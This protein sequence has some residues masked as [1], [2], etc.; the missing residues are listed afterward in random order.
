MQLH[1]G[2][3]A[4]RKLCHLKAAEWTEACKAKGVGLPEAL[5]DVGHGVKGDYSS[6]L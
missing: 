6:D 2:K 4:D 3:A 1:F 5:E